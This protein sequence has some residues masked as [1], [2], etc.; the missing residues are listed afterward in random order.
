M[1]ASD[2]AKGFPAITWASGGKGAGWAGREGWKMERPLGG[3]SNQMLL[4]RSQPMAE[5]YQKPAAECQ[6][7]P[8]GHFSCLC[9]PLRQHPPQKG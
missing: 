8:L 5:A 7:G 1:S 6:K 4:L 2:A 3:Q 9:P